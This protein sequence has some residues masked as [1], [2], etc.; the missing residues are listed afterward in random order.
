[1][2]AEAAE[3]NGCFLGSASLA[4]LFLY[5]YARTPRAKRFPFFGYHAGERSFFY[6]LLERKAESKKNFKARNTSVETILA[7]GKIRR[8][9]YLVNRSSRSS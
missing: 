1:M 7:R 5:D 6:A 3:R 4:T 2:K 8:L 9:I